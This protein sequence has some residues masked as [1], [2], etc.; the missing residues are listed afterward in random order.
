M[1]TRRK[2]GYREHKSQA[3]PAQPNSSALESNRIKPAK[4]LCAI[5]ALALL[6]VLCGLLPAYAVPGEYS[7]RLSGDESK[8]VVDADNFLEQL[9]QAMP[10]DSAKAKFEV[11]NN[12]AS[13]RMVTFAVEAAEAKAA[14]GQTLLDTAQLKV[15]RNDGKAIYEGVLRA[16]SLGQGVELGTLEP[17]ESTVVSFEVSIPADAGNDVAMSDDVLKCRFTATQLGEPGG[18]KYAKTG[19]DMTLAILVAAAFI[20]LSAALLAVWFW[21]RKAHEMT[22]SK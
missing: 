3:W 16:A 14:K 1:V 10:G 7:V 21:R 22:K 6:I 2:W 20:L 9:L 15:T 8:L 17:G 19:A 5:A 12:G 11:S 18:G 4:A 13:T